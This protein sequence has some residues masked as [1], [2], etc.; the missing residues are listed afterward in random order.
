MPKSTESI[1]Q[2]LEDLLISKGYEV[3][4]LDSSGKEVPTADNADLFQFHF[5]KDGKDYGTVTVSIDGLQKMIVYY[6]DQ[7]ADSPVNDSDSDRDLG[8][9]SWISLVKQLKKFALQHQLGFVL[10][11]TDRLRTDMRR[12]DHTKKLEEGMVKKHLKSISGDLKE[13]TDK[14]FKEKYKGSKADAREY[15]KSQKEKS[16]DKDDNK[17]DESMDDEATIRKL[18]AAYTEKLEKYD[19]KNDFYSDKIAALKKQ[20]PKSKSGL[21]I[22]RTKPGITRATLSD[23]EPHTMGKKLEKLHSFGNFE[24]GVADQG[25]SGRIGPKIS[26][27]DYTTRDDSFESKKLDEGYYGNRK[28][29]YSDDTPTVKMVIKHNRQLEETDQRFRHIERIFLET[30]AG[31]RFAVETKKPSRA[32]MFARHLA[33]GG[34]YRDERWSHL[35]EINEDLDKLSGFVRATRSGREQFNESAQRMISEAAE[36]YANLRETVKH[37]SSSRGYNRYFESYEP[38]EIMED[39]D[40]DMSEAFKHS[41]LDERIAEALPTLKKFGIRQGKLDE[42]N[43]FADWANE[44]VSEAL[45]PDTPR[46]VEELISLFADELPLGPNADNI[47]GEL[48][49]V[50]EDDELYNRLRRAAKANP[51][52]DARPHIVAWMQEQD[53]EKYRQALD[54]LDADDSDKEPEEPEDTGP[55]EPIKPE[56]KPPSPSPQPGGMAAPAGELPPLP[57]LA[58]NSELASILRLLGR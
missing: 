31:E 6:D 40:H 37:L 41:T 45:D 21:D 46:Q 18:I 30:S 15:L 50:I 34:Q 7:V 39:D 43:M 26:R 38:R 28:M 1:N 33:E 17:L 14:E 9:S 19:N 51:D 8:G 3:T 57:P 12:R 53:D 20:L 35:Q 49:D 23:V 44:L 11:D 22:D 54:K 25:R 47:L 48:D 16:S 27:D 42:A 55:I 4:L 58:E 36:Q 32:R 24:P 10:K 13:L 2:D 5:H 56:K 29:S 52:A